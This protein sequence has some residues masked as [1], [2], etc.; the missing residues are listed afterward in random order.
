[1]REGEGIKRDVRK[2][3]LRGAQP[4]WKPIGLMCQT[5]PYHV[6]VNIMAIMI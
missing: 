2:K 1:M 4:P 3:C 6:T 5:I